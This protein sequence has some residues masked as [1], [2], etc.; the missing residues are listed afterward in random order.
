MRE[1]TIPLL[2]LGL[3][4]SPAWAEP[5]PVDP[6][7]DPHMSRYGE[8]GTFILRRFGQQEDGTLC[9]P[10]PF[11]LHTAIESTDRFT[12]VHSVVLN[13]DTDPAIAEQF[14]GDDCTIRFVGDAVFS[15]HHGTQAVIRPESAEMSGN[16]PDYSGPLTIRYV[17]VA[18]FVPP[19]PQGVYTLLDANDAVIGQVDALVIAEGSEAPARVWRG[20]F[21]PFELVEAEVWI[22][23]STLA[24]GNYLNAG[25]TRARLQIEHIIGAQ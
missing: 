10:T 25:E 14:E 12:L 19:C 23:G 15:T 13:P 20:E 11:A 8:H 21:L 7:R 18:C 4:A 22:D 1:R 17:T 3:F 6:P 5:I 9:P 2:L 16:A 24:E